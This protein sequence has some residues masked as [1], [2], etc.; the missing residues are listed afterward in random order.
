MQQEEVTLGRVL[1][2]FGVR[3]E[4]RLFLYNRDTDLFHTPIELDLV[5]PDGRRETRILR[6]RPGAGK[7]IIGRF[8]GIESKDDAD[9]YEDWELRLPVAK[10]PALDEDVFYHH[11]LIGMNVET[12]SGR[13]LGRIAEVHQAK[14]V[15]CWV[16]RDGAEEC[17]LAA[18]QENVLEVRKG[19]RVLVAEHVGHTV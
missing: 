16:I 9:G 8:E 5:S 14:G 19:D 12:K 4:L 13:H 6:V 15:D 1:S 2:S 17:Y 18:T 10:L 7:R 11:E 3:G